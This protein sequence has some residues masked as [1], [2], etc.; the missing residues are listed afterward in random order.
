MLQNVAV[1]G[2]IVLG[3]ALVGGAVKLITDLKKVSA[4]PL[5]PKEPWEQLP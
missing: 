3:V 2:A 5:R 1:I 4:A